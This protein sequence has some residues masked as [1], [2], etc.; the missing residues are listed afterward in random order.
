MSSSTQNNEILSLLEEDLK[1]IID[2]HPDVTEEI[3][4]I[5]DSLK[6]GLERNKTLAKDITS[7]E[8]NHK[9]NNLTRQLENASTA[10]RNANKISDTK[11]KKIES[12]DRKIE[13]REAEITKLRRNLKDREDQIIILKDQEAFYGEWID[14][15]KQLKADLTAAGR[16][17]KTLQ[18]Q[19]AEWKEKARTNARGINIVEMQ[20]QIDRSDMQTRSEMNKI[21]QLEQATR[22]GIETLIMDAQ[23]AAAKEYED[24]PMHDDNDL[25]I[26]A[27]SDDGEDLYA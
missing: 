25:T 9:L 20:K 1:S 5:V 10:V 16:E 14:Q 19:V 12:R 15:N 7:P 8:V 3:N 2:K 23:A 18:L 13:A 21:I 27:G 6:H 22:R 24:D 4:R 26:S 11:D 17:N